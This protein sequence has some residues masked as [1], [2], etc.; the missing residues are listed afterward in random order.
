MVSQETPDRQSAMPPPRLLVDAML[1][2][3]AR[4]LRLAGYDAEFWR[5]GS[6]DELRA[7]AR[8]RDRL[9]LTKDHALA[10][11]RG[12]HA[13]LIHAD[14]LDEQIGEAR[15]SLSQIGAV[16]QPYTRCAECNG[17]LTE[18]TH[19][20][21]AG[22]VPPYVWHT[23]SEFRRCERCGRVYWK[24]THWPAVQRRLGYGELEM[25]SSDALNGEGEG[26]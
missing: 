26:A 18:L 2:K 13:V 20:D 15:R 22:L 1:G 25:P 7:A 9:V 24:G 12:I 14:G 16:P 19:A 6:D 17:V 23:Q 4:W 11:R 5:E 10:G 21:A 8:E 3:L